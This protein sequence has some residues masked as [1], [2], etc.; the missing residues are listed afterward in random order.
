M[1]TKWL[2]HHGL[3][4]IYQTA[5]PDSFSNYGSKPKKNRLSSFNQMSSGSGDSCSSERKQKKMKK[6]VRAL[7]SE[8]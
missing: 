6:M 2:A 3:M 5:S 8:R 4:K 1:M 7:N